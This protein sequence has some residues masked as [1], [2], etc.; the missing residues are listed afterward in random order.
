M[1]I[2]VP[3]VT[4]CTPSGE[5]DLDGLKAVCKDVIGAG[6]SSI[7]AVGSTGRGPWFSRDDRARICHTVADQADCNVPVLAGC[8]AS[9]LPQMLENVYAMADAGAQM[10]VVTAPGY[11]RY[12]QKEIETVFLKFADASPL[13]VLIYDIPDLVGI[14]LDVEMIIRLARHGNIVGIKDSTADF[15]RFKKLL[16]G[17]GDLSDFYVFQGKERFLADSLLA[18]A[19]GFVVSLV[20]IDPRPFVALHRAVR[21]GK[22]EVARRIQAEISKVTGLIEE[23]FKQR[24]ETSTLFH[25]LNW[26]LRHRRI[27]D[28]ILLDHEQ[29]CPPWLADTARKVFEICK[30]ASLIE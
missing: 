19:S 18:G 2:V 28:N 23:S 14:K 16:T 26:S 3:I 4:P 13:P 9:G 20:Q 10:A 1:S 5:L 24:P 30:A 17:L 22:I 29:D 8:M 7:F 12:N 21:S 25:F 15:V 11:F 6:C 27:C